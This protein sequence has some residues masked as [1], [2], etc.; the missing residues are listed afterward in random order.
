MDATAAP[1]LG[2]ADRGL[3]IECPSAVTAADVRAQ[4]MTVNVWRGTGDNVDAGV[5][6]DS[7]SGDGKYMGVWA[8]QQP[9]FVETSAHPTQAGGKQLRMGN[10]HYAGR[11][12]ETLE[13]TVSDTQ[14]GETKSCN[15]AVS[16]VQAAAVQQSAVSE[17][18]PALG[19]VSVNSAASGST[20]GLVGTPQCGVSA[21]LPFGV[22][23]LGFEIDGSQHLGALVGNTGLVLLLS[24]VMYCL[25]QVVESQTQSVFLPQMFAYQGFTRFPS[26]FLYFFLLLYQGTVYVSQYLVIYPQSM[27]QFVGGIVGLV[28]CTALPVW[29]A[30]KVRKAVSWRAT[31]NTAEDEKTRGTLRTFLLG[32]GEWVAAER[33]DSFQPRFMAAMKPYGEPTCWF[34]VFFFLLMFAVGALTVPDTT[35]FIECG[36]LRMGMAVL[37]AVN[38]LF[39]GWLRPYCRTRDNALYAVLHTVTAVA[40]VM[41]GL[42][43]YNE[44]L[45]DDKFTLAMHILTAAMA[46]VIAKAVV[47]LMCDVYVVWTGRRRILQ[48]GLWAKQDETRNV[49]SRQV[50]EQGYLS[51]FGEIEAD[52]RPLPPLP[53]PPPGG[54]FTKFNIPA[55]ESSPQFFEQEG[56]LE[57]NPSSPV[58]HTPLGVGKALPPGDHAML[59][60]VPVST[61]MALFQTPSSPTQGYAN[62][63]SLNFSAREGNGSFYSPEV[64][65]ASTSGVAAQFPLSPGEP[66]LAINQAMPVRMRPP[67]LRGDGEAEPAEDYALAV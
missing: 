9:G 61:G 34:G 49:P 25:S 4:R 63:D 52:S 42:A 21:D 15:V 26:V 35:D 58:Q 32:P 2:A 56:D 12:S 43:Y 1:I 20:L 51:V 41:Q 60:P 27:G 47:D 65:E 50:D 38:A 44:D 3:L 53:S 23:P 55:D 7:D 10:A 30:W 46:L 31:Y 16:A 19:I 17:T 36:H 62:D 54:L 57:S 40:M 5:A 37:F 8:S 59:S 33:N 28:V 29:T 45:E 24:G 18:T 22:H 39:V 14:T 66:S 6:V 11:V 64:L 13:L 67:M 48:E